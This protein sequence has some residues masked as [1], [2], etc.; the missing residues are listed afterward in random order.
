[1]GITLAA[2]VVAEVY[3]EKDIV[4]CNILSQVSFQ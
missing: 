3:F 2:G 1:M 4:I